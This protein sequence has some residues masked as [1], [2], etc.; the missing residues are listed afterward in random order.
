[1]E[2]SFIIPYYN[3]HPYLHECLDSISAHTSCKYE[4]IIIDDGSADLSDLKAITD[5]R[6][7]IIY[8]GPR[9]GPSHARNIGIDQAL[10]KYLMFVDSDDTLVSDPSTVIDIASTVPDGTIADILVGTES[11]TPLNSALNKKS[12]FVG[13]LKSEPRLG[14]LHYFFA[15]LY[16]RTFIEQHQIRF[17]TAMQSGG[18]L[19]F[20]SKCLSTATNILLTNT[21]LYHYRRR[22][23]SITHSEL[24][25][26]KVQCRL[27][28]IE[29]MADHYKAYPT[30]RTLR[31]LGAFNT[32][33][34]MTKRTQKHLGTEKA[35]WFI[36]GL[37]RWVVEVFEDDTLIQDCK[38]RYFV[39]WSPVH[40]QIVG[41]MRS[42]SSPA[43]ILK[44][45]E[46]F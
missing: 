26:E 21:P 6:A 35:L 8:S 38:D 42:N 14:R 36:K 7:H 24:T 41:A 19:V 23:N 31:A 30:A 3:N 10:G 5:P 32:N 46:T 11:K 43:E 25:F 16:R 12:P 27:K 40:D 17:D 33:M 39:D 29:R 22:P 1:M 44:L 4:V 13:C 28:L 20:L 45:I 18:D 34:Y 37:T 9:G 2:I 15:M